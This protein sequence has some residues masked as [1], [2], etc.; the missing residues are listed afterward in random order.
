LLLLLLLVSGIV[1]SCSILLEKETETKGALQHTTGWMDGVDS[2]RSS[3]STVETLPVPDDDRSPKPA[4]NPTMMMMMT[5]TTNQ[6]HQEE[7]KTPPTTSS[8]ASIQTTVNR[9][10]PTKIKSMNCKP[11]E[12]DPALQTPARSGSDNKKIDNFSWKMGSATPTSVSFYRNIAVMQRESTDRVTIFDWDTSSRVPLIAPFA[13]TERSIHEGRQQ[14]QQ[15]QHPFVTPD[16]DDI[17]CLAASNSNNNIPSTI[18]PVVVSMLSKNALIKDQRSTI[19]GTRETIRFETPV[20]KKCTRT[21]VQQQQQQQ[22]HPP[23]PW[24]A[25]HPE[26]EQH[27]NDHDFFQSVL[28]SPLRVTSTILGL[29][30]PPLLQRATSL[31]EDMNVTG[32]MCDMDLLLS[33]MP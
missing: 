17:T 21:Q 9:K 14:A 24:K 30:T 5:T 25:T 26:V 7:R 12:Q 23:S 4:P 16:H 15:Q 32:D 31:V 19:G 2:S 27:R 11:K 18:V 22:Q 10:R 20:K 33:E 8:S 29:V 6:Q 3:S 1:A 13:S 28:E